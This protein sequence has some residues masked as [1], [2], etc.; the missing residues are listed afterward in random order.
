MAETMSGNT[1]SALPGE[2]HE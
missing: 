1:P 2:H